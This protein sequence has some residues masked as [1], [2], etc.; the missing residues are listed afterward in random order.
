VDP[1]TKDRETKDRGRWDPN[2]FFYTSHIRSIPVLNTFASHCMAN[3]DAPVSHTMCTS[4]SEKVTASDHSCS[5]MSIAT[6]L[7]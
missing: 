5:T 6:S 1:E 3:P 7:L 2:V 4:I